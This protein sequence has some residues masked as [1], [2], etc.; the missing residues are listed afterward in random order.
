MQS[1]DAQIKTPEGD[2]NFDFNAVVKKSTA[3][4]SFFGYSDFGLTLFKIHQLEENPIE[5]ESSVSEINK[6]KDFFLQIFKL[7]KQIFYLKRSDPNY[8][9]H[10]LNFNWAQSQ[11]VVEFLEFDQNKIPKKILVRTANQSQIIVTTK[12]YTF[13][14]G[15]DRH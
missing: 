4:I 12:E 9:D 10:K 13:T 2:K 1:A 7:V 14:T 5:I 8:K 15:K 11:A 3:E 6:N